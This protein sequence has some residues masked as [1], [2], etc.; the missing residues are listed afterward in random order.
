MCN[1][2]PRAIYS[3]PNIPVWISGNFQWRMDLNLLEYIWKKE[4]LCEVYPKFWKFLTENFR[5][6]EFFS[7]L[8][9]TDFFGWM[10]GIS[11][12]QQFFFNFPETEYFGTFAPASKLPES[13]FKW[14]APKFVSN[15]IDIWQV[16]RHWIGDDYKKEGTAG[17]DVH[18]TNVPDIRVAFR[19]ETLVEELSTICTAA[20]VWITL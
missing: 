6:I 17:N 20:R 3:Q 5:F 18:K 9:K 10:V 7:R 4:E 12:S 16:K 19:H 15:M 13:L 8:F 2:E 14:Q 11:E 1:T